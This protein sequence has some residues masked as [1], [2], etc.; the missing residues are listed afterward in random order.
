[1]ALRR[2]LAARRSRGPLT[3]RAIR[4]RVVLRRRLVALAVVVGVVVVVAA[5]MTIGHGSRDMFAGTWHAAGTDSLVI[6]HVSGAD[7]TV[8]VGGGHRARAALCSGDRLTIASAAGAAP[9]GA[10]AT[11]AAG[12]GTTGAGATDAAASAGTNAATD[13]TSGTALGTT[14]APP[15]SSAGAIVLKPGAARGTLEEC[16]ADGTSAVLTRD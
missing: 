12:T 8:V 4:R 6:S 10:A 16:F 7:Y 9:A 11:G 14:D 1:V 15:D 5:A 2:P 3:P 13:G